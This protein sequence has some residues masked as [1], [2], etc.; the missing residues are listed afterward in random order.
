MK[1]IYVIFTLLAGTLGNLAPLRAQTPSIPDLDLPEGTLENSPTLQR[2]Q[3]NI[4]NVLQEIQNDP[5]FLTRVRLGYSAFP[6]NDDAGGF[7]VGIEDVFLGKT[8]LTLSGSYYRSF[9]ENRQTL[10]ADL[11][12]YI[13]PLGSVVNVAPVAGFRYVETGDYSTTGPNVGARL[14][15]VP[16]RG[17]GADIALTQSFV[18]PGSNDEVGI[19]SITFGYALTRNLRVATDIEKQNSR[20]NKD[21]RVSIGFE[22]MFR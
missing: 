14:L 16:S 4:P 15:L 21:S 10:G 9:E 7:H 17:G 20:E 2:W 18:S 5:S 6:S 12:Y 13:L 8:R 11:R 3:Q 19:T 22:W 1:A